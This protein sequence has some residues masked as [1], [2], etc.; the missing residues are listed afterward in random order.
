MMAILT[1]DIVDPAREGRRAMYGREAQRFQHV[2][3]L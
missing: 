3:N 1:T 2:F